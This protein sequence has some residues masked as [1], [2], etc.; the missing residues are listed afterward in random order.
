M[1]SRALDAMTKRKV[2]LPLPGIELECTTKFRRTCALLQT[3][4]VDVP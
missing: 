4:H 3:E 1:V 2:S